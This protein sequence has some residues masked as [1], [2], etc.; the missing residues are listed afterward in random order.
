MSVN[1]SVCAEAE[2]YAYDAVLK[3]VLMPDVII[4]ISTLALL[5]A[6]VKKPEFRSMPVHPNL[7]VKLESAYLPRAFFL[8]FPPAHHSVSGT[9]LHPSRDSFRVGYSCAVFRFVLDARAQL[10]SVPLRPITERQ[11]RRPFAVPFP[12]KTSRNGVNFVLRRGTSRART[13]WKSVRSYPSAVICPFC[14]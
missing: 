14:T 10:R 2:G 3:L 13:E 12:A 1:V 5:V 7:K 11:A 6:L 9:P 4:S 8:R